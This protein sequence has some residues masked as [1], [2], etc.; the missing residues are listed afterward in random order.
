MW[1]YVIFAVIVIKTSL[2]GLG[3]VSIMISCIALLVIKCRIINASAF[4]TSRAR[5][6]FRTALWLHVSVYVALVLKLILIDSVDDIPMFIASHLIVHHLM[7]AFI[8]ATLIVMLIR[9]YFSSK[10][11]NT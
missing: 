8:A 6:I 10:S 9:G 1:L 2:L 7:A 3:I 4:V 11:L 5:R